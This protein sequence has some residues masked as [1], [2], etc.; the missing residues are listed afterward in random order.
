MRVSLNE[1]ERLIE[2]AARG[3][4]APA[5]TD[6]DAGAYAAWLE[7]RGLAVLGSLAA[8]L[9]RGPATAEAARALELGGASVAFHAGLVVDLA[10]ARAGTGS[11][12]LRINDLRDPLLALP[13]A[14]RHARDGVAFR[15]SWTERGATAPAG[16][17]VLDGAGSLAVGGQ[18]PP[19]SRFDLLVEV[20]P[21][22]LATAG[23]LDHVELERRRAR[24]IRTGVEVDADAWRRLSALAAR[25]YVPAS[26][27]SRARGAGAEVDDSA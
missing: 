8:T 3:A 11:R 22:S 4:G 5:G 7:A 9:G 14:A 21:T 18:P 27:R 6:G 17:A 10:I 20:R 13:P 1:I 16:E 25:T 15:L 12:V 26:E 24:S 23:S 19:G 2:R